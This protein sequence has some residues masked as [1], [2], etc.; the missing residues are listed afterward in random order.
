MQKYFKNN[1]KISSHSPK[2]P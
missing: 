1:T 2:K